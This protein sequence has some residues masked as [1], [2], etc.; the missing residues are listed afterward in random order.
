MVH[1]HVHTTLWI[2]HVYSAL[3]QSQHFPQGFHKLLYNWYFPHNHNTRSITVYDVVWLWQTQDV[4]NT[5]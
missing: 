4:R 3:I 5:H 1:V 2:Y